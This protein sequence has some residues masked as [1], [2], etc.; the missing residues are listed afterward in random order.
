MRRRFTVVKVYNYCNRNWHLNTTK[1]YT[2]RAR[3]CMCIFIN[4]QIWC[5]RFFFSTPSPVYYLWN[6]SI[7][8]SLYVLRLILFAFYL[9]E[10]LYYYRYYIFIFYHSIFVATDIGNYTCVRMYA[11]NKRV[12]THARTGAR[13]LLVSCLCVC[14]CARAYQEP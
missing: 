2:W 1:N 13:F 6:I 9:I 4:P 8:L 7:S 12:N 11:Y 5:I 3:A 14:V 10:H